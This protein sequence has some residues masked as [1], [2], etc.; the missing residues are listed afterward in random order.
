MKTIGFLVLMWSMVVSAID[1][2]VLK[3]VP[4]SGF[5]IIV[6]AYYDNQSQLQ[7][8]SEI[9]PIWTANKSQK[10]AIVMVEE[11]SEYHDIDGLNITMRIDQPL[12][13]QYFSRKQ[14][15]DG[16]HAINGADTIP[17]FACYSTV[18]GTFA[19]MDDMVSNFPNLATI[20]DIGDSWEKTINV[21]NGYDLRLL[22]LTNQNITGDKPIVFITTAIHA[23][24]YA[25]AELG[26]RFAEYL[27]NQYN[28][29]ADVKWMLDHHEVQLLLHTNPDGRKMA[30]TGLL[31]RKNTNQA[32]CAPGS[33]DRG[34]DLNRNYS[35]EWAAN[36]QECGQTFPGASPESEPEIDAVMT[37][38]RSI[39]EDNRGE[40]PTDAAPE[41]T[42]GVFLDIHSFSQLILWPWGFTSNQSPNVDQLSAFG[43]RVAFFSGYRPQPISDLTIAFGSSV[44]ATYGELGV[45]SLAF[46]LGTSFFQDCESFE[47]QIFPDNLQSLLYITR[48]ARTPY[49]SPLGPDIEQLSITPN[50]ILSNQNTQIKGVANDDRYNQSNGAQALDNIASVQM[51][52]NDLPWLGVGAT[53]LNPVDG[54]FDAVSESFSG[55]INSASLASGRHTVYTTATDVS[56]KQG[57]IFAHFLNVVSPDQVGTLSGRVVNAITG[58]NVDAAALSIDGSQAVSG[59]DGQYSMLVPPGTSTLMIE[60]QGFASQSI[61]DVVINQQQVTQQTIQLQPFCTIFSDDMESGN[62]GWQ[63][64]APWAITTERSSSPAH[65]WSDSPNGDYGNNVDTSLTSQMI[66]IQGAGALSLSFQHYCD[67]E[68]GFDRGHVE[69]NYDNSTWQEV[70]R[71]D[72]QPQWQSESLTLQPPANAQQLQLRFRLTSD[73]V[74][75]RD[76][77]F[78]DDVQLSTT[79]EPCSGVLN[80]LIYGNGFE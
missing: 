53:N 41:D 52:V 72:G 8:L 57:A 38:A 25:T 2:K 43:K 55:Q 21:A 22:K 10:F 23:R 4:E 29:N 51:F 44:D 63:A 12:Q 68:A 74:V 31:W 67:T 3:K 48:V 69:V 19:R 45:A 76:G 46:E 36:N 11:A 15:F 50:Y 18:E 17:G 28:N 6:R 61:D 9:T 65:A 33:N 60:A 30:E 26:T 39:F 47:N 32:Y 64:D 49:I 73:G 56:G 16:S 40:L 14:Q 58:E 1:T 13:D 24:E 78:I 34:A 7:K 70:L 35:F 20:M 79:G 80:D 37:Y 71:C 5:P 42:P 77:W 75:T 66:N 54:S 62:N 27:L 59:T